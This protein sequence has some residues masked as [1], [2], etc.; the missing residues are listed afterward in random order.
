MCVL[1]TRSFAKQLTTRPHDVGNEGIA[2]LRRCGLDD[3]I[4]HDATQIVAFFN[5]IN[6][7]AD[8]LGLDEEDFVETWEQAESNDSERQQP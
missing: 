7:V 1:T 5:Y 3:S 8:A 4:I 2:D 6:R